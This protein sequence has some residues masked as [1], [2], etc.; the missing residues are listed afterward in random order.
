MYQRMYQSIYQQCINV[1][2][3]LRS[4]GIW[5]A[6]TSPI[7]V[8]IGTVHSQH[9]TPP[10]L[11]G[12]CKGELGGPNGRSRA[13]RPRIDPNLVST[14]EAARVISKHPLL[15]TCRAARQPPITTDHRRLGCAPAL[16]ILNPTLG[17]LHREIPQTKIV[18]GCPEYG[19]TLRLL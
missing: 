9:N 2:S 10:L 18:Q 11:R 12:S 3:L 13:H 14:F 19:S 7:L 16:A 5:Y 6:S 17:D 15:A 1:E 4:A 8:Y